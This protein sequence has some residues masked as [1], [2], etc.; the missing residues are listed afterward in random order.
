MGG[1]MGERFYC[2]DAA[3]GERVALTGDEARHLARVCRIVAGATVELFDGEGH[4][5]RATVVTVGKD[6]VE[7]EPIGP[8]LP[9]RTAP[10]LLTLATAVPKGDRFDWL[11]EKATELGVAR[12]VP[13]VTGRSVVDPRAGKLDRL[14]RAVIEACKQCGRNRLM[15]IGPA[16]R[17]ADLVAPNG[18]GLRLIAH[19][20]GLAFP[21]WPRPEPARTAWLAIGPE[22]GFTEDEVAQA[23]SGGWVAVGLGASLLRVETAGIAGCAR[24]LALGE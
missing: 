17:W 13:I 12:L 16:V 23:R 19:P 8:P 22:G 1:I 14:R 24:L 5:T 18:P 20:D 2:V 7:L 9:D 21:A 11:V 3:R 10:I 4:A 6:R 15:E